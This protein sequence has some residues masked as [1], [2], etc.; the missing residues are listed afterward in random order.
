MTSSSPVDHAIPTIGLLTQPKDGLHSI[1]LNTGGGGWRGGFVYVMY[2][3][4]L[5]SIR[6]LNDDDVHMYTCWYVGIT[7]SLCGLTYHMYVCRVAC[8]WRGSG[9]IYVRETKD[10]VMYCSCRVE[11]KPRR[12]VLI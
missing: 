1:S 9:D 12:R 5:F 11:T 2:V 8:C 7:E 4:G 6:R 10:K 3:K